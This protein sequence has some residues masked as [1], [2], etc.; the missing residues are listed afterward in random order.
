MCKCTCACMQMACWPRPSRRQ[1]CITSITCSRPAANRCLDMCSLPAVCCKPSDTITQPWQQVCLEYFATCKQTFQAA[2]KLH[3]CTRRDW[4]V[5]DCIM[6]QPE[7][8]TYNMLEVPNA[9]WASWRWEQLVK[10]IAHIT[11]GIHDKNLAI[12]GE[13]DQAKAHMA[14]LLFR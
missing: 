7:P 13:H 5:L 14:I 12:S 11:D 6:I 4:A 8:T 10:Y 9:A 2:V 1:P 3:R